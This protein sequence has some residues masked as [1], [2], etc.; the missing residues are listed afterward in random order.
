MVDTKAQADAFWNKVFNTHDL[1]QIEEFIAP[2]SVNHNARG[3]ERQTGHKGRVRSSAVSGRDR[4]TCASNSSRWSER[5]TKAVCIGIMHGT[6]DG[7]F[8]GIP[9]TNRQTR[10]RH[11]HVLTF[12]QDGLI[13]DHLAVRDDAALLK[14]LGT[15]PE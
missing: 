2:G 4:R 13:T 9:A 8:Q 3:R 12:D 10:A 6:H 14:Q 7:T 11:I 1:A 15:I 5:E